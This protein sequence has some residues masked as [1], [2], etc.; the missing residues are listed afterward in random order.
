MFLCYFNGVSLSSQLV[1][2]WLDEVTIRVFEGPAAHVTAVNTYY[3]PILDIRAVARRRRIDPN[4]VVELE[5]RFNETLRKAATENKT[6]G[7]G[8][9]YF[10]LDMWNKAAGVWVEANLCE[11]VF[12]VLSEA[13]RPGWTV[14]DFVDALTSLV[15]GGRDTAKL[16]LDVFDV[17]KDGVLSVDEM[18][19]MITSIRRQ[20]AFR[21]SL[22]GDPAPINLACLGY[23]PEIDVDKAAELA[24]GKEGAIQGVDGVGAWLAQ[25]Q[26]RSQLLRDL[27]T[28]ASAQFGLRPHRPLQEWT[29]VFELMKMHE[30][31]RR[32]SGK[33]EANSFKYDDTLSPVSR[34]V[35][36]C[37]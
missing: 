27:A 24:C 29:I 23:A 1:T 26:G 5:K 37:V 13:G 9:I 36:N 30:A 7:S 8:N 32:D 17:D 22:L 14:C 21:A 33:Q 15:E 28:V 31:S 11:R 35:F 4:R 12:I 19:D 25:H 34:C 3:S 18:R 6:E 2:R 16:L 10:S 20:H